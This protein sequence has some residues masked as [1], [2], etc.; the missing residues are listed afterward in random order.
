MSLHAPHH[1]PLP[2]LPRPHP[3]TELSLNTWPEIQNL[4]AYAKPTKEL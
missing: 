2:N 4:A 3:L 1:L